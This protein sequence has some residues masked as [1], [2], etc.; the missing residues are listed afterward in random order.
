M[1]DLAELEMIDLPVMHQYTIEIQVVKFQ[2]PN[3]Q[4][5]ELISSPAEPK[6]RV[7]SYVKVRKLVSKVC[8][9]HLIRVNDSSAEVCFLHSDPIV[10]EF[11]EVF[12]NDLPGVPCER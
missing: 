7:I 3:E 6:D 11:T 8:I 9:Y 1:A 2:V 4:V 10:K 12:L 5:I